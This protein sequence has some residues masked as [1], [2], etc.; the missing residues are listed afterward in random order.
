MLKKSL[1]AVLLLT[2]ALSV[3]GQVKPRLG[4]LPFIGGTGRD[5]ETVTTLLSFQSDILGNFSVVPMTNA[6]TAMVMDESYQM[7][8]FPDS[9][10]L[11]RIG[12]M[13]S[14]DYVVS[15]YIRYL[16]DRSLI[17]ANVVNVE[18]FELVGGYYKEYRRMD[19]IPAM[20]PGMAKAIID[21][22]KLLTMGI[23]KLAV[24]PFNVARGIS[25]PEVETLA[26]ILVTEINR[27]G[28]YMVLPRTSSIQLAKKDLDF[29][30]Q[31]HYSPE[32]GA[33]TLGWAVNARYILNTEI[34]GVGAA[35]MFSASII[36]TEN[37]SVV[38]ES[39]RLYRTISEG[40]PAMEE[41]GWM[42]CTGGLPPPPP[43]IVTPAPAPIPVPPPLP[44][45]LP[46]PE[47]EPLP[48]LIPEP[49]PEP[50]PEPLPPPTPQQV[51]E[52]ADH[53]RVLAP[54]PVK[55]E[56]EK[57]KM[58]DDPARFWSIGVS[59]GTSFARPWLIGTVRATLAPVRYTFLEIG[60]DVG[61]IPL[62]DKVDFYVSLYPFAHLA[63][64]MPFSNKGGFYIGAGAGYSI[65]YFDFT[66]GADI[67]KYMFAADVIAGVNL[68]NFL[69]ISYTLRAAPWERL[70]AMSHK[71]SIGITYR[72]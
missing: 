1:A 11:S 12:R 19:E 45:P 2:C 16:G 28:K 7:S 46:E 41:L 72:F 43:L 56:K 58:F 4:I 24:A 71:A 37:G 31:G 26:Q 66:S 3:F 61:F 59:A 62:S 64:F 63:F 48:V 44:P 53:I 49:V 22:S 29:Q 25:V 60:C 18:T 38:A 52:P 69:D 42:L 27:S 8:G 5:G 32:D 65:E 47:P 68:F 30:T 14:A 9:D 33:R 39:S 40:I 13:L 34:Y 55:P 17:I 54:Q 67:W 15:G 21:A 36:N 51:P 20:L 70:E 57:Y 23:P 10:Y 35:K 6:A 50:I